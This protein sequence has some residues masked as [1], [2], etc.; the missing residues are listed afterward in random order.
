M[1]EVLVIGGGAAGLMAAAEA[2]ANG[3]RV[4]LLE[5]NEKLGK[6]I[7]I[8]GKGRCNVTNDCAAEAFRQNVVRNPRF[9]YSALDA[10][11]PAELREKLAAWGCPTMVE[12]G[13]RVFPQSEKASD[14]TRA[15]EHELRR[16]GVN[17][18]LNARVKALSVADGHIAGA[19][20]ENGEALRADAVI[21]CTGGQ[22][23]PST[24]S[25]GDGWTLLQGCGHTLLPA[26]P[27]L[28]P[29]RCEPGWAT[30]LMGLS[31][32]NVRLTLRVGKKEKFSDV[33][34][35]LFTHFG[36]SGP[37][38]LS[39]SSH[40]ASEKLADCALT[41]DL[42][43]GLNEKQL[44][45]RIQRDVREAG[46]KR[47]GTLLCGLYPARLADVMARLCGV[48][49]EKMANL[50][51][52]EERARLVSETK[53]LRIPV[54]GPDSLEAAVV[55]RG[56]VDVKEI[57]PGTMESK[58]VAGLYAAGEL[59]DVDALTGGFNL[60]IAFSTGC[61]AGRSAAKA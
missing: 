36:V 23:Y 13:D 14:V 51:T 52:R 4:T 1:N 55:T 15:F 57:T 10:L 20:L 12:R 49:A 5:R 38:V 34:G 24:G 30:S 7:Y 29:L 53:A 58:K 17:V 50:L 16:L 28:I 3:A 47:V 43:P 61:L 18:R 6:K 21:V 35:M 59:L 54:T 22:S 41:L 9:L 19:V 2:A 46:K 48:D 56:G 8:T 42:K 27:S 39:A 26:R 33:G 37:L 11:S 45:E 31:L 40:M 32:R 25:T 60:Q 44:D